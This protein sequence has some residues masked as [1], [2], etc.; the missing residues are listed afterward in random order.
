MLFQLILFL[1]WNVFTMQQE[2]HNITVLHY[3]VS[4]L[5][6]KCECQSDVMKTSLVQTGMSRTI[7]I[8]QIS[9]SSP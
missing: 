9:F 4:K 8:L 1:T 7:L 3:K 6:L 2:I 5:C